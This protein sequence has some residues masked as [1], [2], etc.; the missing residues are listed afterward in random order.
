M[1]KRDYYE[2]LNVDKKA[3]ESEIKKQFRHLSK[4]YHPDKQVGK[5][6]EEKSKAE[7]NF[8]ELN[9][10]YSVLSDK[11]KRQRYDQFGHDLGANMGGF[12]GNP[13]DLDDIIRNFMGGQPQRP[14]GPAPI[15][16]TIQLSLIELF[17]G[18]NK[19]F[20]Y[21]VNRV[22]SH[23]HGEKFLK[24]EGGE[25][26]DCKTCHGTGFI[27]AMRGP[28]IFTQPCHDCGG[29]G[30]H[31]KNGCKRCNSS[32][33]TQIDETVDVTVP[34]G[35][36]N[37]AYMKFSGKGNEMIVNGK[38]VIGD[39]IVIINEKP[40]EKFTR[41]SDDLHCVAEYSIY[42]CLLGEE[43]TV[44]TI[45]NKKR[46]FRLK[47]GT[48][49]GEQFRLTGCGMPIMNTDKHGDL[50]VHIK[51]IMPKNISEKEKELLNEIKS[52]TNGK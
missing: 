51:H 26:T 24:S 35:A 36:P 27:Q 40:D 13:D 17:N 22:C 16:V 30:H 39:L 18:V 45:D 12:N 33:L 9:E 4:L 42:D 5:S 48:E 47:I 23:C 15:K 38:S 20:K 34:K 44:E 29:V 43:I 6:D 11:E 32:G 25:K 37:G 46:K 3:S 8:K 21:K 41:S 7:E 28:M 10:A 2:V 31:I 14:Q 19:K 1:D 50:Y 49:N 52:I